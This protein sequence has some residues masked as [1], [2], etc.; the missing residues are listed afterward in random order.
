MN[1]TGTNA[2]AQFRGYICNGTTTNNVSYSTTLTPGK[3]YHVAFVWDGSNL[4]LY[5]NGVEVATPTAQTINCQ[6]DSSSLRIGDGFGGAAT[7]RWDGGID[8]VK[9]Y[10]YGLTA[11]QV[12]NDFNNGAAVRFY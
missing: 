4:H 5:L 11:E 2:T 7:Y 1:W 6:D 12:Q 9:V 10:R 3:W 8:E